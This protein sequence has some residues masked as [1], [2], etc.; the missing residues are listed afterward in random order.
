MNKPHK[1]RNSEPNEQSPR[2]IFEIFSCSW[3]PENFSHSRGLRTDISPKTVVGCP[4][5]HRQMRTRKGKVTAQVDSVSRQSRTA[6]CLKWKQKFARHCMGRESAVSIRWRFA[7]WRWKEQRNLSN[8]S[9]WGSRADDFLWRLKDENRQFTPCKLGQG[10]GC[11]FLSMKWPVSLCVRFV[12][13]C[14]SFRSE[15]ICIKVT[16]ICPKGTFWVR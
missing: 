1:S 5:E 3:A 15:I 7:L 12:F 6:Q 13:F 8:K 11:H 4:W 14:F 2:N 9:L 10:A 16:W